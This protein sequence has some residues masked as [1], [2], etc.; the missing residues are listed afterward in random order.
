[1]QYAT[2]LI[3]AGRLAD[4][5][6]LLEALLDTGEDRAARERLLAL[7]QLS[8]RARD[9]ARLARASAQRYPADAVFVAEHARVLMQS[10]AY[11]EV[12]EL[13]SPAA[14][15]DADREALLAGAYQRLDRHADAIRHYRLAVARDAA[16]ARHWIGLGISQEHAAALEDALH[17]YRTAARLGPPSERLR[18]FVAKRTDTL[19]RVLH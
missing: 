3:N 2:E 13:L 12:V 15:L 19:E 5:E 17:S 14:D 6:G 10:A 8:G 7:Y 18:A 11:A 9:F 1:M 16:D 4:A